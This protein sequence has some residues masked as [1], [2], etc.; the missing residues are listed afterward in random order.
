[1]STLVL[2]VTLSGA[3]SLGPVLRQDGYQIRP[4]WGFRMRPMELFHGTR[5]G[6]VSVV[7]EARRALSAALSDGA[8]EEASTMTITVSEVALALGPS[9]RDELSTAVVRHLRDELALPLALEGAAVVGDSSP[10]VQVLGSI[11]RGSQLRRVLVAAF[12]GEPRHAVVLVSVAAGRW[13]LERPTLE[14][15]LETF[16]L[17]E[18]PGG[19]SRAWRWALMMATA[20]LLGGSVWLWSRQLARERAK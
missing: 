6:A 19:P 7:P 14:A 11:K 17:D 15:S 5:A 8:G 18:P 10:R 20:S 4:P 3:G 1:M 12:P 16:R 9:A 13:E 2:L